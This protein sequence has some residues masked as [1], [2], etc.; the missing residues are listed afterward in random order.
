MEESEKIEL[1]YAGK[2]TIN[3]GELDFE[4]ENYANK[5]NILYTFIVNNKIMYIGKSNKT[6]WEQMNN[7]KN[8]LRIKKCLLK[9]KN[10]EI[11]VFFSNELLSHGD[12][13]IILS[14]IFEDSLIY[15]IRPK[16]NKPTIRIRY[17]E[18]Q[19]GCRRQP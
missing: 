1:K 4:L 19:L 2:W 8:N 5:I 6:L 16:W 18:R 9:R 3:D 15:L 11:H 14:D 17:R 12:S 7:Y 13:N 10:V